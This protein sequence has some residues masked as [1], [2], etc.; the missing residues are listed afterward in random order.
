MSKI[1]KLSVEEMKNVSGGAIVICSG[2][3]YDVWSN[4]HDFLY[5][6][7][8]SEKRAKLCAALFSKWEKIMGPDFKLL[9]PLRIK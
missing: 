5:F 8:N 1:K 4:E 3:R 7:F 2:N 9:F 6:S